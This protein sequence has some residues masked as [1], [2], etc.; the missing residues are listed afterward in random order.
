[1]T[2]NGEAIY[3]HVTGLP[4]GHVAVIRQQLRDGSWQ[5]LRWTP[6]QQ[7]DWTSCYP[8]KEAALTTLATAL[9]A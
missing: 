3:Y 6:T 9:A 7:C 8:S 1:M 2:S 5:F 4:D